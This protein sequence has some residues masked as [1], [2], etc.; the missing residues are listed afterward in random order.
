[1]KLLYCADCDL[2]T[3]DAEFDFSTRQRGKAEVQADGSVVIRLG[4]GGKTLPDTVPWSKVQV[5]YCLKCGGE[6]TVE[7]VEPCPHITSPNDAYWNIY[8]DNPPYRI[9]QLCKAKQ[10]AS[11]VWPS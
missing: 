2:Y 5:A 11:W 7:D 6:M 4:S 3:K 9:C 1:M 8:R 10:T